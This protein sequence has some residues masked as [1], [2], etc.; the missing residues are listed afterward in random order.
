MIL[1]VR[2]ETPPLPVSMVLVGDPKHFQLKYVNELCMCMLII[3]LRCF[4]FSFFF[5]F[6]FFFVHGRMMVENVLMLL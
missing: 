4:L 1:E 2:K 3:A 6:F 5:F